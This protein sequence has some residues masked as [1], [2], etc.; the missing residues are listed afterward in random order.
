MAGNDQNLSLLW[1]LFVSTQRVRLLLGEAMAGAPL[2]PDEYA[3]YSLLVDL[4]RQS[5]TDMA[6]QLG[7]PP[8]TMSHYVRALVARGHARRTKSVADGRSYR[9]EIT[10]A[11]KRAHRD[12]NSLF[13]E[14]NERFRQA[15]DADEAFLRNA[16]LQVG[17]AAERAT[18]ELR[19]RSRR[20]SA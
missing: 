15:L 14:A 7:I 4:G 13:E 18:R 2:S 17:L 3:V 19:A 10:A 6:R 20:A 16:I 8:T 9:L 1:H 5:P 12:T 11:G